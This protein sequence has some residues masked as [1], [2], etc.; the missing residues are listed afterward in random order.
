MWHGYVKTKEQYQEQYKPDHLHYANKLLTVLNQLNPE[1]VFC[2][3]EEQAEFI[4]DLNRGFNVDTEALAD[5][6]T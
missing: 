6:L 5:A 4:E 3:N 1:K 2:L